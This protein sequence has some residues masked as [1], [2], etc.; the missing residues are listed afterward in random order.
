MAIGF[1]LEAEVAGIVALSLLNSA[2]LAEIF[3]GSIQAVDRGQH[4][5]ALALG[6][7]PLGRSPR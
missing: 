6:P 4:G 7:S 1:Q 3:R 5:A 2:Y